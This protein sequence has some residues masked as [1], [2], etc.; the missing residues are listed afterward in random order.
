MGF[1]K[2]WLAMDNMYFSKPLSAS[3]WRSP[4]FPP[5]CLFPSSWCSQTLCLPPS[6]QASLQK[7]SCV[8]LLLFTSCS[9]AQ[10]P[11]R[12]E[13]AFSLPRPG[14]WSVPRAVFKPNLSPG[15]TFTI[16]SSFKLLRIS[17]DVSTTSK[18]VH[19]ETS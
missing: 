5:L 3:E 4:H 7:P 9:S 8:W 16:K 10:I 12:R 1:S 13:Q 11:G 18:Q 2:H 19:L 15:H 17:T 14:V 6:P